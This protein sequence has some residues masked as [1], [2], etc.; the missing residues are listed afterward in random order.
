MDTNP[1]VKVQSENKK[2]KASFIHNHGQK[3]SL[4]QITPPMVSSTLFHAYPLLIIFDNALANLMWLSDDNCLPFI[5]LTSIWL[6]IS[7]FI[8]IKAESSQFLP[9]DKLL[10]LW[11]GF[12]SGFFLLLSF[13]Y[14]IVSLTTSLRDAEPPTLDEI[15]VL[16]ESVLAKLEVIRNELNI[17]NKLKFSFNGTN[18]KCSNNRLF[19]RL[20][21][22]GTVFQIIIMR[23]ISVGAYTKFFIIGALIF[24]S[25]SFQATLKLLWRFT[26]VRSFYYL[27]F[28]S[29]SI[30]SWSSVRLGMEQIII[31]SQKSTITVPLLE[32]LPRLLQDK[33]GE[34]HI[35]F[36]QLLLNEH[37]VNF[38]DQELKI[39]E[40]EVHENQRKWNQSKHWSATLLPYE[41]QNFSIEIEN[42][43]GSF[44][45]RNCL[46]MRNLGE[47]ELPNNW[48]W[49]NDEW[50]VTDWVYSDSAWRDIGK[51]SSLESFT[52]SRRWK[53][54]LFHL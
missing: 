3:P 16:L 37:E 42:S 51:Y 32:V 53:R 41:R 10:S 34:D 19:L 4:V 43:D 52:R 14:Y 30:S 9:F 45:M 33:K 5:Y 39:L 18:G 35:R 29:F 6:T 23:Y 27:G 21:I 40:I 2:I 36:L 46:P 8:P 44:T 12:I 47:E 38:E 49:I 25:T 28:K 24:H 22:L 48:H 20:F 26:V 31:L 15:V 11:L 7:F 54:R 50:D 13:M 1:K 17:W